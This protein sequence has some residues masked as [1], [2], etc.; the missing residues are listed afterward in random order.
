[1]NI[2]LF[3]SKVFEG[4]W[5]VDTPATH[6]FYTAVMGQYINIIPKTL[7]VGVDG[8]AVRCEILG[9]KGL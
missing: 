8:V 4:S 2:L 9:C 1:M 6:L 5:N 3:H 7:S